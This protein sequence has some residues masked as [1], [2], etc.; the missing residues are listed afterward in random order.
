[1]SNAI[2]RLNSGCSQY[3]NES[4]LDKAKSRKSFVNKSRA[5]L[6][7]LGFDPTPANVAKI[8]QSQTDPRILTVNNREF[9]VLDNE[10]TLRELEIRLLAHP[11]R[12]PSNLLALFLSNAF[13]PDIDFN[14]V[15]AVAAALR[16]D[17]SAESNW[18]LAQMIDKDKFINN[19]IEE[20]IEQV[21]IVNLFFDSNVEQ[22]EFNGNNYVIV[23]QK[24]KSRITEI[25]DCLTG[26]NQCQT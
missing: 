6:K 25:Y 1:M 15:I 18:T 19:H 11:K 4:P 3:E 5:L 22:V 2:T 10:E 21:G 23:E 7:M 20:I 17:N 16:L 13:K 9:L 26:E 8:Q 12:L 14:V 24:V